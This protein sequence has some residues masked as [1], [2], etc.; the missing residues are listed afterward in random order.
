MVQLEANKE[1]GVCLAKDVV[2]QRWRADDCCIISLLPHHP[3]CLAGYLVVRA[4]IAGG[5]RLGRPTHQLKALQVCM[6]KWRQI[7]HVANT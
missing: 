2:E 7:A 6:T 1:W 5:E 4:Y 3:D